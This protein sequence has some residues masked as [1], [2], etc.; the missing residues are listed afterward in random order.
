MSSDGFELNS[1]I[2]VNS[3][4]RRTTFVKILFDVMPTEATNLCEK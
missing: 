2:G 1:I 4:T 3:P